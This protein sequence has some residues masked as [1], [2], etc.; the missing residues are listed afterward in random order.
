MA[1]KK[2]ADGSEEAWND[3]LRAPWVLKKPYIIDM[4]Y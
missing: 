3:V 1:T 4:F 2:R